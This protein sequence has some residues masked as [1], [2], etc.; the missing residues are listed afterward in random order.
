MMEFSTLKA[1]CLMSG[2]TKYIAI[3]MTILTFWSCRDDGEFPYSEVPQIELIGV[4]HD[5]LVEYDETLVLSIKY[6]DGNGDIGFESPDKY[7]VHVRDTRLENFD[8]FYVGPVAPP[9][10]EVP[11]EGMIDIEF[12]N[13][14]VFGNGQF[15]KTFFEI[16]MIDRAGNESNTLMSDAVVI[17]KE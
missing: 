12:P 6:Q 3:F 5:S 8:G 16:K 15:E 1:I 11:V 13:L 9:S 17:M 2:R 14:F 10:S 4:S 7:A